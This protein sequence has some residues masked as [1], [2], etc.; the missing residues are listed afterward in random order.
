MTSGQELEAVER[1]LAHAD[2]HVDASTNE[3][4]WDGVPMNLADTLA[5]M[6]MAAA[7][8]DQ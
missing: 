7:E 6:L 8:P 1:F 5:W 3:P 4:R 2:V